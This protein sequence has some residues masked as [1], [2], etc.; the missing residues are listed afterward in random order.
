VS[1]LEGLRESWDVIV[2]GAGPAGMAAATVTARA[3]LA[4]LVLDENP[5]P[6]GQV[7]RAIRSTPVLSRPV[8]GNDYWAG[9]GIASSFTES[10]AV[11]VARTTV[12]SLTGDREVGVSSGGRA[13][14][15]A[16]RRIIIATGA[17]ER[18]FPIPGWT[19]PGVMTIGGAQTVLKA[20]GL[21]PTGRVV[22]AGCG[23]LLWL[24]ADQLL[25]A[26]GR[27]H[28][29]LDTTD[30]TCR[31]AALR[32]SLGFLGSPYVAK[33]L[34]LVARV[35][36]RVRIIAGVTALKAEGRDSLNEVA[37]W[38]GS[39]HPERIPADLLLLHHGVV[40]NVNLAMAAGVAHRWDERQVCFAPELDEWGGTSAAGIAVAGDGAG[41]AGAEAAVERGRLAGI[42][43][44]RA[45]GVPAG[46]L[47]APGAVRRRL[48]R[49][50]RAR[51]FLDALYRPARSFRIPVGETVVCRCED[52][53]A[54]QVGEAVAVG[55]LGPSQL[56]SFLRCGMG[57][58][59]GR[60]CGL[61]VTELIADA[62]GVSPAEVGYFR[63]RPPVKP[64]TLAELAS[65]P[66]A[67]RAR[68]AVERE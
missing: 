2:I 55:C 6:G 47:P 43:A 44:A 48:R 56:K 28:A 3:G 38:Q 50:E 32:H 14:L 31:P 22:L 41:I 27:I 37:V 24:Y 16:G 64:I 51:A 42:A 15:L 58:C 39:P 66:V 13:R 7:W 45:L 4:T 33:G 11:H 46:E 63:L 67:E 17:L 40:P 23:P 18:P 53:T 29:V 9:R 68:R 30:A 8:L 60:L 65:L 19:L 10:G 12:W 49:Y 52:V 62:R 35:R 57:P 20:S 59:Q 1:T 61:T 21:V 26:G 36:R 5:E 25:A 54:K 34:G